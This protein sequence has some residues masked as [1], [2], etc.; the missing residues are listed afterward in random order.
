ML[1]A[2]DHLHGIT[3][4]AFYDTFLLPLQGATGQ[5]YTDVQT[6]W[7]HA[8]THSGPAGPQ[9]RS[10]LQVTTMQVLPLALHASH[11]GWAQEQVECLFA[12]LRAG[13]P[14]L[15]S[16]AFKAGMQLL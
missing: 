8:A 16:A 11:D 4:K 2:K 1:L 10:G 3:L 12:P 5:P 7:R 9:A 14:S 13:A 6:W 15:S